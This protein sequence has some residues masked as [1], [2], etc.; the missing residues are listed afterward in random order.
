[1]RTC[2]V[3]GC[4]R[5]VKPRARHG[6]CYG[7]Y[8]KN[9]RY[10]T[11]TPEHSPK[12]ADLT[13][14]TFGTLTVLERVGQLWRCA[15]SCGG[16]RLA[17]IGDLRRYGSANT[18]GEKRN[19]RRGDVSYF[20]AHQ[21]VTVERGPASTYR[22]VDCGTRA[23]QWSYDHGDPGE[24]LASGVS[25]NE[26]PYSTDPAHYSP[27]CVSCHKRFDLARVA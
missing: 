23:Q 1:M 4:D 12:H 3:E 17:R 16:Q 9:W 18:C 10:G 27:R 21:R 13:G 2:T 25:A 22:C 11:P 5:P 20:T 26:V 24:L 19:H 15:C 6:F 7:H 8:M 14:Q